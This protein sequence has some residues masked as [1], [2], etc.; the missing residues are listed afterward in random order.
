[1]IPPVPPAPENWVRPYVVLVVAAAKNR[2]IGRDGGLPWRI[3]A[4]LKWFKAVT[5]GKPV[6][7]GRKTFESIGRPLPD[8][9][10]MVVT[11]NRDFAAE[12]AQVFATVDF[13]IAVA[14]R[15]AKE[16]ICVIGGGEIYAYAM[17]RARRIYLSEVDAEVEGDTKFPIVDR[18]D[19]RETEVGR[20]A[21][22]EDGAD[23]A[24]RFLVLD[25]K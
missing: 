13:A 1:V 9:T 14:R 5:T 24:C 16:E 3:P 6:V 25:R 22:G 12:G 11:R 23:H 10:N 20:V 18:R 21:K 17:S 19:W 2:V 7:M 8:R 4:D 15:A